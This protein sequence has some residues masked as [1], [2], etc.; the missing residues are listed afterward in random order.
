[1]KKNNATHN[2]ITKF[3]DMLARE[4]LDYVQNQNEI[5]DSVVTSTHDGT[6]MITTSTSTMETS[7]KNSWVH[8][9]YSSQIRSDCDSYGVVE[10]T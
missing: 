8:S 10:L 9:K 1:M 4:M 6:I 2:S 3:A 7:Q 5:Q